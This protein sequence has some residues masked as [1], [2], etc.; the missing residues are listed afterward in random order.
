MF[1]FKNDLLCITI[2]VNNVV[3]NDENENIKKISSFFS[4][5]ADYITQLASWLELPLKRFDSFR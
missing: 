2:W 5:V 1:V 3:G 4:F